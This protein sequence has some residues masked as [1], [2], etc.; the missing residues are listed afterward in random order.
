METLARYRPEIE[1]SVYFSCSEALQ[2][3][4]KH[5]GPDTHVTIRVWEDAGLHFTVHD[6]GQGFD[7]SL[8]PYGAGLTNLG[9]RLAALG[10]VMTIHSAPGHGV[11][12]GGW[13]PLR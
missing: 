2:N 10:G 3:A 1:T 5:G 13:I 9:E 8:T 4:A 12:V 7:P 11:V 6:D